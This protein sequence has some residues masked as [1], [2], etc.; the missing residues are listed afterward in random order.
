ML[1]GHKESETNMN[2]SLRVLSLWDTFKSVKLHCLQKK[3][4]LQYCN[5]TMHQLR[6]VSTIS[7][8]IEI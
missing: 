8:Q 5:K 6:L 2:C 7:N 1:H 3:K 4:Y